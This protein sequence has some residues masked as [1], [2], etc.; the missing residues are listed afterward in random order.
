MEKTDNPYTKDQKHGSSLGFLV[1]ESQ[2]FRMIML[3]AITGFVSLSMY[4]GYRLLMMLDD[5]HSLKDAYEDLV[6][7][8]SSDLIRQI[9]EVPPKQQCPG[10]FSELFRYEWKGTQESCS[11]LESPSLE[12]NPSLSKTVYQKLCN[13]TMMQAGCV[14][15]EGSPAM[16]LF[17]YNDRKLCVQRMGD[18]SFF[19][20]VENMNDDGTCKE[21]FKK[22]GGKSN[23]NISLCVNDSLFDGGCP[24]MDISNQKIDESY[25]SVGSSGIF[26]SK[27]DYLQGSP[28]SEV[29]LTNISSTAAQFTTSSSRDS[30][31]RNQH[32]IAPYLYAGPN[33]EIID[34]GIALSSYL[35]KQRHFFCCRSELYIRPAGQAL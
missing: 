1:K 16:P 33:F 17:I 35:S 29:K 32:S 12:N 21:G 19:Y 30:S 15:I 2:H 34:D 5:P 26:A 10:N 20:N 7:N 13:Y 22:C 14:P 25:F 28:I 9:I 4:S 8:W 3:L 31:G 18:T 27:A 6:N 23:I 24:I 11:C